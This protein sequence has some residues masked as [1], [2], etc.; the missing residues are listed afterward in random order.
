MPPTSKK[1]RGILI[2]LIY[3]ANFGK[4]D[5]LTFRLIRAVAGQR[6]SPELGFV[7]KIKMFFRAKNKRREITVP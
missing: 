1:L 2:R 4:N 5:H 6:S 7:N 3:D